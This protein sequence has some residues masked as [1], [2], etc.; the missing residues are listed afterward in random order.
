MIDYKNDGFKNR[1]VDLDITNKCTL[2][3]SQCVRTLWDYKTKDI[4]GGDLT[5]KEWEDLTDYFSTRIKRDFLSI[6]S[7]IQDFDKFL[8]SEQ[9]QPTKMSA[10]SFLKLYF[11]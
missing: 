4:P 9:K 6:K 7:T 10:A 11:D 1:G 8:Y 5:I 3:C 2:Q